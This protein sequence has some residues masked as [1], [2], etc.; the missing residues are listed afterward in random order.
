MRNEIQTLIDSDVI[1]DFYID[2]QRE[3]VV[4]KKYIPKTSH[5]TVVTCRACG[6]NN[7]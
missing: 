4:S 7:D 1:N 2:Y 6:A 5:K 3:E